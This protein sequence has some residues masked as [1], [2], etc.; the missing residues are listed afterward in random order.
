MLKFFLFVSLLM[1]GTQHEAHA[2]GSSTA[3]MEKTWSNETSV[4]YPSFMRV[5]VIGSGTFMNL[6]NETNRGERPPIGYSAGVLMDFGR[7]LFTVETGAEYLSIPAQVYPGTKG[8]TGSQVDF[9]GQYVGAPVYLKLNYIERPQSSFSLKLGAMPVALVNGNSQVE[10]PSGKVGV[11]SRNDL[12]ALAGFSGS[13]AIVKSVS[14]I[15]DGAY[16]Y[17]LTSLDEYG[18]HNQGMKI[19]AGVRFDL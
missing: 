6:D 16:Y 10:D 13:T 19:G 4:K 11:V 5:S 14:F 9:M 3:R 15:I 8:E 1:I 17:G 2:Q 12:L 7:S 18:A